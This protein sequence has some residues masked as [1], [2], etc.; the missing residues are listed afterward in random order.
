MTLF[1]DS[2]DLITA[3]NIFL[4]QPAAVRDWGLL[5][6]ALAR[7]KACVFG[8]DAYPTIH[9]KAAALLESLIKNH[10]LV[11]GNKRTAWFAVCL[12][13]EL[14]SFTVDAAEDDRFN[15]VIDVVEGQLAGVQKIAERLSA[16]S[17]EL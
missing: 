1:P 11:D 6:S 15:V 16:L 12:F 8:E 7:P 3:A 2:A 10:A 17:R 5:E 13:Y 14:N 4:G 9:E